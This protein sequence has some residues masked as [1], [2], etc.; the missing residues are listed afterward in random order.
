MLARYFHK[1]YALKRVQ[2]S[3]LSEIL[4]DYVSYLVERG[5]APSIIK[6]YCNAVQHFGY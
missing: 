4:D 3:Y 1:P 6:R 2:A 5:H